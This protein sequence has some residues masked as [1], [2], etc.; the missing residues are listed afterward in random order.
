MDNIKIFVK[1]KNNLIQTIRI[2][3]SDIRIEFEIKKWI[4]L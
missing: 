1:N 2:I 4:I 3:M